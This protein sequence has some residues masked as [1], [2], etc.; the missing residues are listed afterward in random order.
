MTFVKSIHY[1]LTRPRRRHDVNCFSTPHTG[2]ET[3]RKLF[4]DS[5]S[6]SIS[7]H[8][9]DAGP[10]H[11]GIR[12]VGHWLT[13]TK[14]RR[15]RNQG[16]IFCLSIGTLFI[17]NDV[18]RQSST[19]M[20]LDRE[21][22]VSRLSSR[23][24]LPRLCK[25]PSHALSNLPRGRKSIRQRQLH[26][27]V[28]CIANNLRSL[29]DSDE[30]VEENLNVGIDCFQLDSIPKASDWGDYGGKTDEDPPAR[31]VKLEAREECTVADPS[32]ENLS[33]ASAPT[34]NDV[35]SMGLTFEYP[36]CSSA[37]KGQGFS[38][39]EA[40][41]KFAGN[42]GYNSVWRH[43]TCLHEKV[44]I[45]MHR[46]S[47][48]F[49]EVELD[50]NR[51]DAL[52][53]GKAGRPPVDYKN[54]VLP[55]YK[56]CAFT[57]IVPLA[58]QTLDHYVGQ[59]PQHHEGRLMDATEMFHLAFQ[60]ARGLYQSQIYLNGKAT[61]AHSDVKP[62]QFLLFEPSIDDTGRF[63]L[64][65]R[66]SFPLLQISDFNRSR[67]LRRSQSNETCPFRICGIKHKGSTYRSPE[68]YM[69]CADQ[70]DSI[71]IYS[72][73]GIFFF[74][75]SDGLDPYYQVNSIESVVKKVIAGQLPRLPR[76]EEYEKF[77]FKTV[78]VVK[79]RANH[80]AFLALQRIMMQ[81]WSYKPEERPSSL[82]VLNMFE[83]KEF[84]VAS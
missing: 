12:K 82:E 4:A 37:G 26:P 24:I 52:I 80:P 64:Q 58:T 70:N 18:I 32:Y 48:A 62:S 63:S 20:N 74:L 45:K 46:P 40:H 5:C 75:L 41:L 57:S 29:C 84:E 47:R 10:A 77:G 50:R 27:R 9:P 78:A 14:S 31:S 66:K 3:G 34:C 2:T 69:D 51:R 25:I 56:Y 83:A 71:D 49:S 67:L 7:N 6:V 72:L 33:L 53:S 54:N 39:V 19:L 68:E 36:S 60:A 21:S 73:G 30:L 42:G 17:I 59:F 28:T 1:R 81:C 11:L 13:L 43:E 65:P 15:L 55:I 61:N 16:I 79:E 76:L 44:I 23:Q 22:S 35:H 38:K 8:C